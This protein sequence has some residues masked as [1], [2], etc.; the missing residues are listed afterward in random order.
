M[1]E[2]KNVETFKKK[3]TDQLELYEQ[4]KNVYDLSKLGYPS[5]WYL[6]WKIISILTFDDALNQQ[7]FQT[8][9]QPI[10]CWYQLIQFVI[11]IKSM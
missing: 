5:P 9:G 3:L 10:Q 4:T 2:V 7:F 8:F 1:S 6:N 11:D